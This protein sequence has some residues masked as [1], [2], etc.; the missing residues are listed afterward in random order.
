MSSSRLSGRK[1][2][3][4][5]LWGVELLEYG[6]TVRA[7][8]AFETAVG[9]DPT[10]ADAW[11]GLHAAGRRQDEALRLMVQNRGRFGEL[12]TRL[13][14]RIQSRFPIGNFVTFGLEDD[15]QLW[16]ADLAACLTER[17]LE[18][19]WD[20][21]KHAPY[22]DELVRF[23]CT[24]W[25][26]LSDEWVKVL[27]FARDIEDAFLHEEAQLY[28]GM[29][30][31]IQDVPAEALKVLEPY[32]FKLG[33]GGDADGWFSF[34]RGLAYEAMNMPEQALSQFQ[35]AFR[36]IPEDED[37]AAKANAQIA[38]ARASDARSDEGDRGSRSTIDRAGLLAEG[39]TELESMIGL[40]PVKAQIKK[41]EAQLRMEALRSGGGPGAKV[42]P[43]HLVFAGPPGT[44]K[45]TVARVIGKLLAGLGVL[46]RGHLVEAHRVDLVGEHLG[47][48]AVKTNAKVDEALDGVLFIDEAY[49]LQNEGYTGGDAFGAEAVQTLLKRAEDDRHR[50]TIILAGYTA[51]IDRLLGTNPGLRSRFAT[52]IQFQSYDADDLFEIA[53]STMS[54]RG[55]LSERASMVLKACFASVVVEGTIDELGNGRFARE[56]CTEALARRDLRLVEAYPDVVPPPEIDLRVVEPDDIEGAFEELTPKQE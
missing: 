21:L 14:R 54:D 45:T 41:L 52:K 1:V 44:G 47:E 4:A 19:A 10:A 17:R 24:R 37:V 32:P 40:A 6:D 42:P 35:Y 22:D 5:W 34:N 48:T 2:E 31:I 36:L 15:R 18:Q 8:D 9:H 46:D 27:R 3:R 29:A 55:E 39:R 16:A 49:A 25:A 28:V 30:L 23:L 26:V 50:L 51:E 56:L 20:V 13:G 7:A 53:E 43:R 12:R 38:T 33:R 11:L